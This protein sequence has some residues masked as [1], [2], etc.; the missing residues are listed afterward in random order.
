MRRARWA[1]ALALLAA[2]LVAVSQGGARTETPRTTKAGTVKIGISLPLTGRFSEPGSD[3]AKGYK[4]WAALVNKA[5]GL[6]GK[7]IVLDIKDDASDQGTIVSDYNRLI[8]SDH[9][10]LLL[11]TFSS[12]LNLPASSVAERNH[13]VFVAPAGGS[14]ALF[15]RHY[16]YYFFAQQATAPHQ[17]DLFSAW[18]KHKVKASKRPK[19]I[20]YPILDDPFTKPVIDGIRAKMEALGI[21]TA[22]YKV[23]PT[24][25][26]D[27]DTIAQ[28][29][30]S[31]GADAVVHGATFQDGVALIRS[32]IKLGYNPKVLFQT[33]AP[34]EA[35]DYAK[36]IGIKN[37]TGVMFAV[38]YAPKAKGKRFPLNPQF[39][40]AYKKAYKAPAPTEDAA[41]AFAAA[42]VLQAAVKGTKGFDQDK[43]ATWLHSHP[44]RTILGPLSWDSDGAPRQA[45]FLAQWQK[46]RAQILS[47][48][49]IRTTKKIIYPKPHWH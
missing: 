35:S 11:G 14:P 21:K 3:A 26:T 1:I 6:H 22:Y 37:T 13:M 7:K 8:S 41:D 10:D 45:F 24:D 27:F 5:G 18:M 17:G 38:S 49:Y 31:S 34:T 39:V 16:H 40:R 46:G 47:P 2:A 29:I 30:K 9:V 33:T 12:F 43:M 48:S 4:I 32:M 36:G 28:Q 20:A 23:Y 25:T 44:V 42:Q 15:A 19:S